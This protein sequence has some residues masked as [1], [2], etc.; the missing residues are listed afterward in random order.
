MSAQGQRIICRNCKETIA[1]DSGNCPH[2]G[3]SVRGDLPYLAGVV[4]GIVILVAGLIGALY[5]FSVVGVLIALGAGYVLYEK[6]QRV[7]RASQ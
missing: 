2:C 3:T 6:R 1:T 7:Q 5:T 4:L